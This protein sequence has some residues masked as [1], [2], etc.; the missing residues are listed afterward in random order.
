MSA[1]QV[2]S[3]HRHFSSG[4][5]SCGLRPWGWGPSDVGPRGAA[6]GRPWPPFPEH[7]WAAPC[8]PPHGSLVAPGEVRVVTPLYG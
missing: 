5:E 3:P 2:T 1:W 8:R 4:G 6:D 7:V